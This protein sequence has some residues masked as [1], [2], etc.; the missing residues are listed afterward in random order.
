MGF[1]WD[2]VEV[3][4]IYQHI[5]KTEGEKHP[6]YSSEKMEECADYILSELKSYGLDTSVHEFSVDGFD[7]TFRNVEGA[8]GDGNGPEL[9]IVSHYDTVRHAPGANDNGSAIA[10]MLESARLL[11]E[12]NLEGNVSFV[13]FNL[14]E[15]NPA[16]G[17]HFRDSAQSLGLS[18]E[19]GRYQSWHTT[20]I[21]RKWSAILVKLTYA[22]NNLET[23]MTMAINELKDEL[24]T[25]ELA[26]LEGDIP[27]FKGISRTNWPGSSAL[28]GSSAWAMKAITEKNDI[29]GVLCLE[30][31]GYTS[32]APNS[33]KFPEQIDPG[34]FETYGTQEN[35]TVGDFLA[36]IGDVNSKSL[37][38]SFCKHSRQESITLPYAFLKADITYEQ[39][40]MAMPDILRSDHAPFWRENIPALLL[41]D[42]ADFRYPYYH[43]AADTIDKLDFDILAKICKA[44]IATAIE[45]CT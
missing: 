5:L 42:T 24:T 39:A 19:E 7:Y 14:E 25:N 9:L 11:S 1:L 18:D 29:I 30:T 34:M 22:G 45:L 17:Q 33:Q 31:M 4:N 3:E 23:A 12:A 35:L 40:A 43:T 28:M 13:S 26:L 37:A 2:R 38:D 8:I 10:V 21:M 32:K 44:T 36:I 20:S 16:L 15:G 27:H 41:T 6:L